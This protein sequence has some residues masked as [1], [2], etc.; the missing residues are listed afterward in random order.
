MSYLT[1]VV[2]LISLISVSTLS[3]F[4]FSVDGNSEQCIYEYFSDGTL[5]IYDVKAG[6]SSPGNIHYNLVDPNEEVLFKEVLSYINLFKIE[7]L[8]SVSSRI[9]FI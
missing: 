6:A 8:N 9:Y 4:E 2:F 1:I 3:D 7:Q 5:I